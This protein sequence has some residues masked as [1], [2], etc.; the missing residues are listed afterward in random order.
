MIQ[1]NVIVIYSDQQRHDT[2]G[3]HGNP[4]NLTP[5]FDRL[6]RVGTDVH[7]SFVNQPLCGPARSTMQTGMYPTTTGCA[8]NGIPLPDDA[9]SLAHYFADG[10]YD[11][12]YIG[13]WH[14]YGH[15]NEP[16]PREKRFDYDYWMV[17]NL[18]EMTSD[19][20][21]GQIWDSDNNPIDLVGYR[22]DALTDI[23]IRYIAQAHEKPFYLF[24]S[25]LEPHHQ[26]HRDDYPAP[27][28]YAERYQSAWIPPD[29]MALGGTTHQHIA[30]YYGMVKRMD[31]AL[32][33]IVDALIS[34]N[35]L[36]NTILLYTS[37]HGCHFKTRNGEYKRSP[38]EASI[39]V[40]TMFY[41]SEFI[42][43]GQLSQLVSL[44]DLPP[45]LL[46]ACDLP[47]PDVM[48]GNS[49]MPIIRREDNIW[50]DDMFIQLSES[51]VGRAIRTHRWKYAVTALDASP[52]DAGSDNYTE[53]E[54]YD[55]QADPHELHN[56]VGWETHR[57]VS[58]VLRGRLIERMVD[59]GEDMPT[60]HSAEVRQGN[61]QLTISETEMY[62]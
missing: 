25:H 36:D 5:N 50:H 23:A 42:G 20:Y 40:P 59:I 61:S 16:V 62:Q 15:R 24:L 12:A 9:K 53:T 29:L 7:Y 4:L 10:G 2:T 30:G 18:L 48:Q 34:L 17:S 55:L 43:G 57:A 41:G 26:N 46:D 28:G 3:I 22:V 47:V 39:R 27:V 45:T 60:I 54:L 56:L 32:G 37:D 11:T 58:D 52:T 51:H 35:M 21:R 13:K 8:I 49:L 33:R 38:H 44:I 19:A 1:P 6:A 31:E 14:L